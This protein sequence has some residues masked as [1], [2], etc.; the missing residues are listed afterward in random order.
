MDFIG[1]R[2]DALHAAVELVNGLRDDPRPD[3][4]AL[5][6]A[7]RYI[8]DAPWGPTQDAALWAWAGRLAEVFAETD[9]DRAAGLVNDLLTAAAVSPRLSAHDGG[10]WHLHYSRPGA[11]LV[12][13]VRATTA[14]ALATML[15]EYGLDRH[16]VCAAEGCGRVYADSSRNGRR[17]FCGP[18]CANRAAVAAHRAR[19]R[20]PGPGG[21]SR[22][23]EVVPG[24]AGH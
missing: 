6:A 13:R 5:L 11:E 8:V 20:R 15:S 18:A 1:Y 7:E 4:P 23:P 19:K 22:D 9:L 2:S 14:F 16:G 3:L 24:L 21:P 17:R 10:P 12:D